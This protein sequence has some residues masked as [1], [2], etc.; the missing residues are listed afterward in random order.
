MERAHFDSGLRTQIIACLHNPSKPS[1]RDAGHN[2]FRFSGKGLCPKSPWPSCRLAAPKVCILMLST[3]VARFPI[4]ALCALCG[5]CG[6]NP[7]LAFF[8][9]AGSDVRILAFL[10]VNSVSESVTNREPK[11]HREN[12]RQKDSQADRQD[13]EQGERKVR[14]LGHSLRGLEAGPLRGSELSS[15]TRGLRDGEA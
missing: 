4:P 8:A 14:G 15:E 12:A 6:S 2:P 9:D 7:L 11:P 1:S 5:L 10:A 13:D 3:V